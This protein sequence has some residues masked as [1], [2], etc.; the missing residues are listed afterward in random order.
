VPPEAANRPLVTRAA[1][2]R[3]LVAIGVEPGMTLVVHSSLSSIG[4]VSGGAPRVV[5]VLIETLGPRGTIVTGRKPIR[6]TLGLG[7]KRG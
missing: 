3:D 7:R 4:R 2:R 1:L 5:S 6:D